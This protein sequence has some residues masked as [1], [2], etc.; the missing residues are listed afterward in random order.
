MTAPVSSVSSA[1]PQIRLRY[2][3]AL[4]TLARLV[5]NTAHRMVYPFLPTFARGLGVD[6]GAVALGVTARA[7]LGLISPLFGS[8]ADRHGRRRSMLAGLT[9]LAGSMWLVTVW[10]TYPALF[11]ALVLA[12]VSKQ[13]FD[14]AMQAYIGDR[15]SY[16]QRGLAIAATEVSWSGAFLICIPALG[17]LIART[18]AWQTP[19]PLLGGAALLA[20]LVLW[21]VIPADSMGTGYRLTLREGIRLILAHRA[22]L[23]G[24]SMGLLISGSNELIGI[25]YGAWMEEAFALKVT[26]LGASAIVIGL[27]ELTRRGS[28]RRVCRPAGQAAS[29]GGG[30]RP[31]HHRL[32][33]IACAGLPRR[34]GAGRAVPVLSLLRIRHRQLHPAD[35]E[36]GARRARHADGRQ[37]DCLLRRAYARRADWPGPV[38]HRAAG[39]LLGRGAGQRA[40]AGGVGAVHPARL[41]RSDRR[42]RVSYQLS[43]GSV[44]RTVERMT[45][46]YE[47]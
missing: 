14:P 21:R 43:Q 8:L 19:Y 36:P 26:A 40:G 45:D 11:A 10:P 34:N 6:L 5:V 16:A 29:S 32:P 37:R 35:D 22:A 28:G 38:Q 31:E 15:V 13:I 4:F 33:A 41:M 23:A 27:A 30:Y 20:L 25:I 3:I 39:E 7:S 42:S 17:W 2:Q 18:D 47:V 46:W 24:L 12:G 9:I 44:R 1:E